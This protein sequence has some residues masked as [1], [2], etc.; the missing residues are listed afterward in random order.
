MDLD[1]CAGELE[2]TGVH[3]V[4]LTGWQRPRLVPEVVDMIMD[5]AKEDVCMLD[6]FARTAKSTLPQARYHLFGSLRCKANC[7]GDTSCAD[8][9]LLRAHPWL[10]EYVHQLTL[11]GASF[12]TI[13]GPD[14]DVCTV[15]SWVAMLPGLKTLVLANTACLWCVSCASQSPAER[16]PYRSVEELQLRDI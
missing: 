4:A 6:C 11:T 12:T 8:F 16:E 7:L 14:M 3:E 5:C 13:S 15:H 9:E 10:A 2:L 1:S